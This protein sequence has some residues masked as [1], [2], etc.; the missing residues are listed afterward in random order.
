MEIYL[1]TLEAKMTALVVVFRFIV[2]AI[3]VAGFI[4]TM[5]SDR[6]TGAAIF[7][8]IVKAIIIVAAIAYMDVWF[9]KIESTFMVVASYVDPGYNEHPDRKSTRLNSSTDRKSVV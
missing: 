9:P 3:M 4:L 2:F 1:P 6:M 7:K 5:S 8:P